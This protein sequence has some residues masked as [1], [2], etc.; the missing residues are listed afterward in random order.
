MKIGR[1]EAVRMIRECKRFFR[2]TFVKRSTGET[3][4]MNCLNGV[5]KH[6]KGG[7]KSYDPTS[8]GLLSVYSMDRKGYRS[9][10]VE[11]IV[12]VKIGGEIYKI[13]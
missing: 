8:V 10:P 3:I 11:G 7:E 13:S 5:R 12:E 6:L 9:I 1:A 2:V 4:T